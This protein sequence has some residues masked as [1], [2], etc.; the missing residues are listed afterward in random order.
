MSDRIPQKRIALGEMAPRSLPAHIIA[1]ERG[2]SWPS[3][4][5]GCHLF[6]LCLGSHSSH[7]CQLVNN[8]AIHPIPLITT[9]PPSDR[10]AAVIELIHC[11]Y[12]NR[13]VASHSTDICRKTTWP[14]GFHAGFVL[15]ITE[16]LSQILGS[17]E[18]K[19]E[20]GRKETKISLL[21]SL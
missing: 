19:E 6:S 11:V 13:H 9:L 8:S 10:N 4:S 20:K 3:C 16:I 14:E 5:K 21:P 2:N 18:G 7:S 15:A 12:F 1:K 17:L